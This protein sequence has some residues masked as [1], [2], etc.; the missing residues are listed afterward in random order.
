VTN[1][2][3][4]A[5]LASALEA[6]GIPG[7]TIAVVDPSGIRWSDAFGMADLRSSR[8]ATTD[9]VYHLFSGTKL[10]TATAVMQLVEQ[11]RLSLDDDVRTFVPEASVL[12]AISLRQLLS[13][14]S[15]LADTLRGLL[16]TQF[17]EEPLP[18]AEQALAH[19]ALHASRAPGSTVVYRNVN[20]ALLGVVIGR[21][22]GV[23]YREYVQ[24]HVLAPLGMRAAFRVT[25]DMRA[26]AATGY[27]DRFDPMRLV[28]RVL[29]PAVSRRLYTHRVGGHVALTDYNLA[30]A[31]IGGLVGTVPD[32]ARFVQAQL[33]G[34]GGVL[35]PESTRLMQTP[36]VRGAAGIMSR[37]AVA[38]GWKIGRLDD[39]FFLNH[40]G[41]GAGFTS[42]L[43]LYPEQG[44]GIALAM[45]TM[46]MPRTMRV[47][48]TLCELVRRAQRS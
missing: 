1:T 13:H 27:M 24:H 38:L 31:A 42:E 47:A 18:T 6:A 9:T 23:E 22:T 12:P 43:R 46:R 3:L 15:G 16:A 44:F 39:T 19:Y 48:H 41:G 2:A 26:Q 21:V 37:E 7:C 40:E 17:P 30:T 29:F 45:N 10:F 35:S 32:F 33:G 34:G 14:Q 28:L 5:Q 36:V 20:Y 11:G 8:A 25:D 4:R